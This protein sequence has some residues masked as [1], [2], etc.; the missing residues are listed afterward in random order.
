MLVISCGSIL[1][2]VACKIKIKKRVGAY[3]RRIRGIG[4]QMCEEKEKN[5]LSS[6]EM[7]QVE[8]ASRECICDKYSQDRG[9]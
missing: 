1:V 7:G 2:S 3:Y 6:Q 4:A 8:R 9:T 5:Y